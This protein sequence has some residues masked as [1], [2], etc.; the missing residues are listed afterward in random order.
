MIEQKNTES[1]EAVILETWSLEDTL[2]KDLRLPDY[3]RIYCWDFEKNVIP[4]IEDIFDISKEYR[5]GTLILQKKCENGTEYFDIIDG[6][7]RL[8]TLSLIIY[9]LCGQN[10]ELLEQSFHIKEAEYY[11]YNNSTRIKNYIDKYISDKQTKC[12]NLLKN[13]S[14]SVLILKDSSLDL[15]Y[16]I[17][18]NTN[19]KGKV[20]TDYD[21]L[22]AHHLY[23]LDNEK[24][25]YHLAT[26]WDKMAIEHKTKV[27]GE[28]IFRLRKWLN[29]DSC[30]EL[31]EHKVKK[32]YEAAAV[33]D[34]IPS[35]G[36]QFNYKEPIQG[37]EH[38]F[39][40]VSH[41]IYNFNNFAET[42]QYK[43]LHNKMT[44]ETHWYIRD[45]IEAF[46]FAY[47]L[48][49]RTNYLSEALCLIM[50]YIS[51]VRYNKDRILFSTVLEYGK[52]TKIA[53]IIDRATSPTFF[54]AEL[55]NKTKTFKKHDSEA[56]IK[57][58]KER[59]YDITDNIKKSLNGTF[60]SKHFEAKYENRK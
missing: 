9:H 17:F 11:L 15:A 21:L 23:Y 35:F 6:Q 13:I 40:F 24:Q 1:Q 20:L 36:E 38:F 31:E 30:N 3:Q 50:D 55:E 57:N 29:F 37:G 33:C 34:D 25:A 8:V 58:I 60:M 47:Y 51:E 19:S 45:V 54:L 22:K 43:T 26:L 32:E 52:N 18:S 46:L 14:F 27:L 59:F 44:T 28:Y 12:S 48:K 16:T 2:G 56:G 42:T 10:I 49:F 4:L 5:L 7:Q 53:M 39:A 41:F